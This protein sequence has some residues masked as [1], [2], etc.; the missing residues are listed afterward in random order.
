ML[1]ATL[2]HGLSKLLWRSAP[3]LRHTFRWL[4]SS[5]PLTLPSMAPKSKAIA[6]AS[7]KERR[8]A[9]KTCAICLG[10][11]N[12]DGIVEPFGLPCKHRYHVDCFQNFVIHTP[13]DPRTI[14]PKRIS[15][16]ICPTDI[17]HKLGIQTMDSILPNPCE[18]LY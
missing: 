14:N 15:I 2:L 9:N 1:W 5:S 7:K 6:T 11:L 10:R 17:P 18:W 16:N 13:E 4:R 12:L 8:E 3:T